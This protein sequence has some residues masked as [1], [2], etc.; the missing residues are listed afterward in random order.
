VEI[1][2]RNLASIAR[3]ESSIELSFLLPAELAIGRVP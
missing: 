1:R 2:L 3:S